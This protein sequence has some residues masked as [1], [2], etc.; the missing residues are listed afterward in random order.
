MTSF[1]LRSED[2]I[3]GTSYNGVIQLPLCMVGSYVI[4]E[5]SLSSQGTFTNVETQP[6]YIEFYLDES[7]TKIA[8]SHGTTPTLICDETGSYM[9][10][11]T[12]YIP[13]G[14]NTFTYTF[15]LPDNT[16][17][18]AEMDKSWTMTFSSR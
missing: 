12:F 3:S 2:R 5:F 9:I 11:Q 6:D 8:T 4:K 1:H 18:L 17:T 16:Y 14:S 10:G 15:M 13:N 7:S